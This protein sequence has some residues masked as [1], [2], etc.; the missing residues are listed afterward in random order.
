MALNI[1]AQN[2]DGKCDN[3]CDYSYDY[4]KTNVVATNN[5]SYIS[6]KTESNDNS[7]IYNTDKFSIGETY[8]TFPSVHHFNN[9]AIGGEILIEHINESGGNNL[10]VCIPVSSKGSAS[11]GTQ[12]LT[13]ILN[14][15]RANAPSSGE[16]TNV[17]TSNFSLNSFVVNK[18]FYSY[19]GN[20]ING[21]TSSFIVY[22]DMYNVNISQ[23]LV[24]EMSDI[25]KP[26]SYLPTSSQG[27]YYNSKGPSTQK[28]EGIYISCRPTGSSGTTDVST[29]STSSS[30]SSE[31]LFDTP[32]GSE[33][34]WVI[35]SIIIMLVL[36]F[37]LNYMYNYFTTSGLK[38]L[39]T[40]G[41]STG[42]TS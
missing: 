39:K 33:V 9:Q 1:T 41:S 25:I 7:V 37:I 11:A 15:V 22:G 13:A 19:T 28:K 4:P 35:I 6:L 42:S 16:S 40:K 23:N 17:N 14:K 21:G 29:T 18:P 2:I 32:E 36:F 12:F 5:G 8:I 3:K 31:S 27:L 26:N 20:D 34:M 38:P 30:S 10:Y 24:N